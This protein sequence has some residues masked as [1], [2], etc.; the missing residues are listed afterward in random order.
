MIKLYEVGGH[1]RDS[2]LGLQSKDIDYAVEAP[3]FQ[4]MLDWVTS[5]HRNV[6]LVTPEFFTVRAQ[7]QDG[8]VRDYVLCRKDGLYK[9]GRHPE[10]VEKGTIFDDL[11]RRDFTI[12]AMAL[13]EKGQ[14]LDP[15][16][17]KQDLHARILRCVGSPKER[18]AED[19]LRILRAIRF[20]TRFYM[21]LDL[22][23]EVQLRSIY[24]AKSISLLPAD[25]IR[26]ELCKS[27]A[28][29][30]GK[31]LEYLSIL[32]PCTR[33]ELWKKVWLKPTTEGK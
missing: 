18:F 7:A 1:V 24:W 6:F 10:N 14:L 32:H 26:E 30:T 11:A 31:T 16:N 15:Y 13:D 25:R 17:G 33:D 28:T 29:D 5:T 19:S 4:D 2:I 27:F 21:T 12:N 9:D 22:D 20:A 8:K 3:S 23:L